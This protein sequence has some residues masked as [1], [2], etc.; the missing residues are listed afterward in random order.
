[1]KRR[2]DAVPVDSEAEERAWAVVRD[3]FGA[4]DPARARRRL[5]GPAVVL[6]AAALLAAALS[7]PGRAVVN[8]VR[9]SIGIVG[10]Q[11]ALFRL[12][13]AGRLLVSGA[14]GTWVVAAD[15]STRRLG[16]YAQASWSPHGLFVVGATRNELAAVEPAT[17]RVHWQLA[18]PV[19]SFP[20]WGGTRAD[21]R[22]AYLTDGR[23][24]VVAGDGTGDRAVSSS[25]IP[26]VWQPGTSRHVLAYVDLAGHVRLVGARFVSRA[27]AGA[28]TLAWSPDGKTLALAARGEVVLFAV[29]TGRARVLH[30]AG[31]RS[32][33]FARD[34]RLAML[35]ARSVIVDG[36]TL[37]VA[38]SR[39]AGIAWSPSGRWLLTSLPDADQWVF[40]QTRGV[41]RVLAVSH[42][43]RQFGG[44]PSLDGWAS[45]Q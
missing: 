30:I 24:H 29:A 21:T 20:R 5:V 26:P 31:V 39:L 43:R 17:G 10:A 12:P 6:V 19:V 25:R 37:F 36:R 16:D 3:A 32:L 38:P 2:F 35:R 13:A 34:G 4:R 1:V 23:L 45:G 9:R 8:A 27:Y 41:Y 42:I 33:A 7:P 28:R 44:E 11:P 22:V 18:R 14:G 40:V 15:G